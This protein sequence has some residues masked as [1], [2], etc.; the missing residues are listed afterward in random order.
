MSST[1]F[2]ARHA[3]P[4]QIDRA[5]KGLSVLGR[6]Q[7]SELAQSLQACIGPYQSVSIICSPLPRCIETASVISDILAMPYRV[8]PLRLHHAE[9]LKVDDMQSKYT[10]YIRNYKLL[11]IEP[12]NA[13]AQRFKRLV[14]NEPTDFIVAVGNE[15]TMRILLQILGGDTYNKPIMHTQ[16]YKVVLTEGLKHATIERVH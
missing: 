10:T 15:V 13:Y 6:H 7:A 2:L 16:C 14:Q 8:A 4:I 3:E 12:P 11:K 5:K 9:R 1:I